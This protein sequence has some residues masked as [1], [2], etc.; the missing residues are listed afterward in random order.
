MEKI[1]AKC[2]TQYAL[3]TPRYKAWIC[4]A[5]GIA[6]SLFGLTVLTNWL[7]IPEYHG[8]VYYFFSLIFC[9][10]GTALVAHGIR[11]LRNPGK[12]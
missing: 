7:N 5:A 4:V 9:V 8:L 2:K 3:P 10:L 1:C 6:I 12:F 11:C